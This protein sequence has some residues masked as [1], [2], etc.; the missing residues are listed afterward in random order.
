MPLIGR[1]IG[2]TTIIW[3]FSILP[4]VAQTIKGEQIDG[5]ELRCI[6]WAAR[7]Y[8]KP[9]DRITTQGFVD[10]ISA[11]RLAEGG[12]V[13]H[14]SWNRNGTFD[15]GPMQINSTHLKELERF[16]VSYQALLLN[17]CE[18]I[19]VGAW[20]LHANL[21]GGSDVWTSIGN[22]N[23]RTVKYN[24]TYQRLIWDQLQTVWSHHLTRGVLRGSATV[25]EAS[26]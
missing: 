5:S 1:L 16:G 17:S 21:E 9:T 24:Q 23:S 3:L 4:A 11:I 6:V 13:G 22:Y 20:I 19:V 26:Q 15:I 12:R 8:H 25:A 14:I 18:N 10:L 7:H 2:C